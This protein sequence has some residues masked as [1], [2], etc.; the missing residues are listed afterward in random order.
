MQQVTY[1]ECALAARRLK[2]MFLEVEPS[3]KTMQ[4]ILRFM[5][6]QVNVQRNTRL[7]YPVIVYEN[8]FIGLIKKLKLSL[9]CSY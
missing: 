3:K 1:T 2:C 8:R 4:E 6:L 7:V 5:Y 9:K